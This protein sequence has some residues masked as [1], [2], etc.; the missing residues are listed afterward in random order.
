VRMAGCV[1]RR[2]DVGEVW[3]LSS[4]CVLVHASS[5]YEW[6]VWGREAH[7]ALRLAP[8]GASPLGE[9]R[10]RLLLRPRWCEYVSVHVVRVQIAPSTWYLAGGAPSFG[11]PS[12]AF[13]CR[14]GLFEGCGESCVKA[15]D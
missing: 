2:A 13:G 12:R 3:V 15:G 11:S 14:G 7:F 10:L 9:R 4:S 8:V 1:D 5:G 6:W